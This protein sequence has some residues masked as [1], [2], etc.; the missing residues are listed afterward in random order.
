MDKARKA[1]NER[2]IPLIGTCDRNLDCLLGNVFFYLKSVLSVMLPPRLGG[3]GWSDRITWR[4]G[5]EFLKGITFH[6]PSKWGLVTKYPQKRQKY[7]QNHS[8]TFQISKEGMGGRLAQSSS[9][10]MILLA[11]SFW[12]EAHRPIVFWT[13]RAMN[14]NQN[15]NEQKNWCRFLCFSPG[16]CLVFQSGAPL[17]AMFVYVYLCFALWNYM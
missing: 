14:Q 6:F 4:N 1:H 12:G 9:S 17:V 2:G 11:L 7:V 8:Q 15:A 10:K 13:G 3:S 5:F 16:C